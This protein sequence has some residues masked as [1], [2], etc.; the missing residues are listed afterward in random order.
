MIDPL[1]DQ[2][3]A[4]ARLEDMPLRTIDEC[5]GYTPGTLNRWATGKGAMSARGLMDYANYFCHDLVLVPQDNRAIF[6]P[7]FLPRRQS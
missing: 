1:V 2:L 5:V 6:I 4:L 7:Q 3:V